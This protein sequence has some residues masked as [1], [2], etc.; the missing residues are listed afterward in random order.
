M[1]NLARNIA[2]MIKVIKAGQES[3]GKP[4]MKHDAWT[5]FVR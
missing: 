3:V 5:H 1:Q 2:F 4:E